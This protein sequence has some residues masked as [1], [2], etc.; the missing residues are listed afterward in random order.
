MTEPRIE[1]VKKLIAVESRITLLEEAP[2]L[3]HGGRQR[4]AI[5]NELHGLRKERESLEKKLKTE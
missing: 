4:A 5:R 1:I 2:R 3:A